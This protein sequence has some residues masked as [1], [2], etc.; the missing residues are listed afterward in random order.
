MTISPQPDGGLRILVA[1]FGNLLQS[2][3]GFGVRLLERLK[4]KHGAN[5]DLHFL[6][7]GIGGITLVQELLTRF[8]VLIVLD[9]IEGETPGEISL[10]EVTPGSSTAIPQPKT[11]NDFHHQDRFADIHYAEPGRAIALAHEVKV[12]PDRVYL[13]GCVP[14]TTELGRD[15]SPVVK[16]AITNG[17]ETFEKLVDNLPGIFSQRCAKANKSIA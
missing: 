8:D 15:L 4:S 5:P 10:L 16:A 9:A 12:L 6:E 11:S 2:D 3:D 13:I 1:G 7:I 17:V 14:R